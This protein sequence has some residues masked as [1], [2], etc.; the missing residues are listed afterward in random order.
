MC[1]GNT[2]SLCMTCSLMVF[3]KV[4]KKAVKINYLINHFLHDLYVPS[5]VLQT[6]Y[7]TGSHQ[8]FPVVI[9]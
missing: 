3:F 4:K 6:S 5:M 8:L 9:S 2:F 1:F 7:Q